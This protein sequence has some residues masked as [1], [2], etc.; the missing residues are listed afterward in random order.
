VAGGIDSDGK[1]PCLGNAL[2]LLLMHIF[3]CAQTMIPK[4]DRRR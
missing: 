2:Q 4:H 3:L 1:E